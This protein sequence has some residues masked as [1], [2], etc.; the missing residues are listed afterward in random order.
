METNKL[1][2]FAQVARVKLLQQIEGRLNYVLH[3]KNT[4]TELLGKAQAVKSLEKA[5]SSSNLGAVVEKTAYTWFNRLIAL[6]FMDANGYQPLGIK[7]VS[8]ASGNSHIPELLDEVNSGRIPSGLRVDEK[9]I[10]DILD[11]RVASANPDNEVYRMLLVAA[12]N[13][14]HEIFPFL[15]EEINDFTELLLPE[16]LTS[17]KSI[18]YDVVKGMDNESCAEVEIIGWLYQFYVSEKNAELINSKKVYDRDELAPASQLFTPKW[19]VQYMVDNTLGHL[20]WDNQS[21][22]RVHE[23]LEYFILPNRT[24]AEGQT[25][26]IEDIRFFEPCVGSGHILS[27]AFDVFY[28]IYA[29]EG[30]SP[31]EIPDLILT[32][33]LWG[34]DIDERAAQM[35]SF[36]LMMKARSKSRRF[37]KKSIQPNI[38][39]YKDYSS[40][41]KFNNAMALGSLIKVEPSEVEDVKV[42]DSSL[43]GDEQNELKGLYRL[44]GQR[45]DVV[46]T[47]P[48]YI[49]SSRMEGS[50]KQYV[51]KH[52]EVAKSD[53]FAAFIIRCLELTKPGGYTGYMTPF[54]WMFISSFEKLRESLINEFFINNLVQLEYSGFDGATVPIC[55][56]TLRNE[57][58][59]SEKGNYI[60]LSDFKGSK[61]QGPK[62][63]EAIQNPDCGWFYKL[64]QNSFRKIP[65]S[66][67]S[68]WASAKCFES[69]Q[70]NNAL[71]EVYD[72]RQGMATSDNLQFLRLWYEEAQIEISYGCRSRIEAQQSAKK[73]FPYNKG[74]AFRKWYGNNLYVVNW[75]NDGDQIKNTVALKYPYLN[76]N[77]DFV[78]KNQNYYFK[79]G[80]TWSSLSSGAIS[81][82]YSPEGFLFDAKGQMLFGEDVVN[83]MAF[84]NSNLANYFLQL[85]TP[86][87]DYNLGYVSKVPT[88]SSS[89]H[90]LVLDCIAISKEDWDSS[91]ASWDFIQN[92]LVR[93]QSQ[94]SSDG[95]VISL[96]E[97]Y[98]LYKFYWTNKFH[99]MHLKEEELNKEFIELYGLQKELT[100]DVPLENISI[101]KEVSEIVNG[102]V[103]FDSQ[104]VF[105]QLI[106]Y[107]LGCTFGRYSL[108]KEGL[109]LANQGETLQD[110]VI[111]VGKSHNEISFLPD[112][113]NIIPVL[114]DEWFEDDIVGRFH[115]F[116]KA[117]FGE[118][119]FVKNLQFVEDCLGKDV[120]KYLTKDF[121]KDHIKRYKKRP[122]YWM[123]SSPKGH[124]KVLVYLHRY[125]PDT[126]SR[127]L[128]NYLR[129][130]MSKLSSEKERQQDI[131]VTG[132]PREQAKA[133]KEIDKIEKQIDDCLEYE[134]ILRELALERIELDLDDGV[135]VNYNKMGKAVATVPGLN[136]A[137]AKKKVRGFDWIDTTQIR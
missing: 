13:G 67:L 117:S 106:S 7:V 53:L 83:L 129:E 49:S 91:E 135:L 34:V 72:L 56:F 61:V 58:T 113:D 40:D 15:F 130:F 3:N 62:T 43:F 96:E 103:V 29:E 133:L 48:P 42:D 47:N 52:Y 92:E 122:I 38:Y 79:A 31:N 24:R 110:Y 114:D 124:F 6:R 22:S 85:L 33:N 121:H 127:I 54:V 118:K 26:S 65:G 73:W 120:R 70:E 35:A 44:L 16:D 11:G 77:T 10:L 30:Y 59:E 105:S 17:D 46:V 5:I 66:P 115:E 88:I 97:A 69:F 99:Q 95:L 101:L 50:V 125:T 45:Y 80:L 112:D 76:G 89:N 87:L 111:K 4:S 37:F 136:D 20:W 1:K 8:S 90:K 134:A 132:A 93:F 18:I 25:K 55:T 2:K 41:N 84:L 102:N 107:F 78:V 23:S 57:R 128:N 82:R 51:R 68:Y 21:R 32:K 137:K 100:P 98:D 63:L 75:L 14:L 109:I 71:S 28:S 108:E 81:F 116:L 64:N 119:N 12:C 36:V 9:L 131:V 74:G 86:T 126:L 19:I 123:F 39:S 27:Y 94:H 60:R 104:R